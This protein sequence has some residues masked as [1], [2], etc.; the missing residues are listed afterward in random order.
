VAITKLGIY[1]AALIAISSTPLE[2]LTDN[3]D[4]VTS[5]DALYD[6]NAVDYCLEVV[7]PKFATM[8]AAITGAA[9]TGGVTLAYTHTL[10]AGFIDVVGVYS[11]AELSQ[12]VNRYLKDG[13][14]LLC[15]Y[16]VIYL[17]YVH[18][19]VTEA[20]FSP[21]FT[22]VLALYLARGICL[23]HNPA[24]FTEVDK[25]LQATFTSVSDTEA[26]REPGTRPAAEGTTLSDAWR[27]IYNGALTILGK[28]KLPTGNT[29]HPHRVA[30]D[31]A[32]ESGAVT[33]V[34]EDT[35]WR[36]GNTTVRI[37]YDPA[38]AP[39][40]GHRYIFQK[41]NDLHRIDGLFSDEM[42]RNPIKEYVD[43]GNAF[44]ASVD[45]IY[46]KYISDTWVIQPSAWP[47]SFSRLVSA[48][49]A[50]D[51]VAFVDKT[52][53]DLALETY[54]ERKHAAVG[55]DAVQS[56]PHVIRG[57]TWLRSRGYNENYQ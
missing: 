53:I 37:E 23:K 4:E 55:N 57:G 8:T 5:L 47:P 34:M 32:I 28:P 25:A 30:L 48:Q 6:L 36:F 9:T 1:N 22:N 56:P 13:S 29:D 17:R 51:V 14:T 44:Y 46:L 21:G 33:S 18:N 15:D 38:G 20:D 27:A 11:D 40:W 10:P 19:G 12:E 16:Q 43:E 49:L 45:T 39:A 35:A 41:P 50:K 42:F 26:G 54:K 52:L 2:T 7:K 3:R 31:T 24:I